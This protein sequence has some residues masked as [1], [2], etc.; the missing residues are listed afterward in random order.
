MED[1]T[2]VGSL[3]PP[4]NNNNN[5]KK[6]NTPKTNKQ[7]K[8]KQNKSNITMTTKSYKITYSGTKIEAKSKFYVNDETFYVNSFY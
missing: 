8:T 4:K 6:K 5:N 1:D 2:Q 7:T 3:F